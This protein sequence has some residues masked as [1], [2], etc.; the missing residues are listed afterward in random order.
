MNSNTWAINHGAEHYEEGGAPLNN[1]TLGVMR[2]EL[3]DPAVVSECGYQHVSKR[4]CGLGRLVVGS[5]WSTHEVLLILL[6]RYPLI[7]RSE[8]GHS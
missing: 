8:R 1:G 4:D 6:L 7:Y 3:G 5:C 2:S